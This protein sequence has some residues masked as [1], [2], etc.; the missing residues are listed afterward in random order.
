MVEDNLVEIFSKAIGKMV[1]RKL[2]IGMEIGK[3]VSVFP[4]LEI[5]VGELPLNKNN[6]FINKELL[7]HNRKFI[8]PQ[9][10]ATGGMTNAN[11]GEHGSHTHTLQNV[12]I[13]EGVAM[14]ET[15]F[16]EGDFVLLQAINEEQKYVVI[17]I[18]VD[19]TTL[20]ENG[21]TL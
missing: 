3:V 19:G 10:V 13:K 5:R 20:V 16:T 2:P 12:E 15:L 17:A 9:T 4:K 21:T 11:I 6:L 14:L 7:Q 1:D 8:L 18:L